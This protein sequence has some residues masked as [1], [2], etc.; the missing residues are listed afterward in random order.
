MAEAPP[1]RH[2]GPAHAAVPP[3]RDVRVLA[4]VSQLLVLAVVLAVGAF[5]LGTLTR[6]MDERGFFPDLGLPEPDG[7]LRDRRD[8]HPVRHHRHLRA[9]PAGGPHQHAH[10]QRRG[11]P[12]RH[13]ARPRG[14]RG[15]AVAEL[16]GG[17]ARA[18]LR[19]A[20]PQHAA[21]PAAPRH[22]LRRLP[23]AAPGARVHRHR[24]RHLS[25][26]SAGCTCRGRR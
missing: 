11:H 19:G 6:R 4:I 13:A 3:W 14:R 7:R 15:T 2:R 12:P 18:G 9:R 17:E 10:G 21:P 24:G 23:P 5:L 1:C 22:L 20:L 25:S 26:T 16:A 8:G